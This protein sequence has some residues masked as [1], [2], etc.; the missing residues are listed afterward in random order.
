[1]RLLNSDIFR[2]R[3]PLIHLILTLS[4][5]LAPVTGSTTLLEEV[6][7]TAQKR[8]QSVYDVGISITAFTGN[9]IDQLRLHGFHQGRGAGRV[10]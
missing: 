9:Q 3:F 10:C 6:V 2:G 1:M 4:L 7:V 5:M 8:E